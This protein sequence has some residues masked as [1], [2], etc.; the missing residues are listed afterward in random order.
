V[1]VAGGNTLAGTITLGTGGANYWL[2]SDV[3]TL[4]LTGASPAA[5]GTA[6][7]S[8][9]SG[10]RNVTLRGAGDGVVTGAV[11]NG[12]A[13]LAVTKDGPGTWTLAGPLSYTGATTVNAGTLRLATNLTSSASL[14]VNGGKVEVAQGSGKLIRTSNVSASNAGA[15]DLKDNK[16]IVAG[17]NTGSFNGSTYSGVQG[18]VQAGVVTTTMPESSAGLTTLG[19]ATAEQAGLAGGTFGGVSVAA[20]DVLVMYTYAGDANLSGTIDPD[21]YALIS[22]NDNDPGA[23][24]YYNGDFNYDG[25]INAD[26]FASIDFNSNAQGAPF[27]TAAVPTSV[28]AVPEPSACGFA[29]LFAVGTLGRCRSR[30]QNR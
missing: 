1:N 19:V 8:A 18:F 6:I 13:T 20:G 17:G 25:E 2:Q 3:G 9:A 4:T 15:I 28:L 21:D 11:N 24:G 14:A 7:T 5:G 26:D 29:A 23:S 12:A 16:L 27:P 10:S 22:F 30:R